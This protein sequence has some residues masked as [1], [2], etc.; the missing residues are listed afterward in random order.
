MGQQL[1]ILQIHIY[2]SQ[3]VYIQ[4]RE[5]TVRPLF[6]DFLV[7]CLSQRVIEY[8]LFEVY[9]D[10]VVFEQLSELRAN[11]CPEFIGVRNRL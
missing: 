5:S 1:R 2:S 6:Q 7:I 9:R 10:D 8:A 11:I 4:L 3:S